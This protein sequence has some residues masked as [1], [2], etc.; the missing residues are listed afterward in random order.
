[1]VA[2]FKHRC[3]EG[4]AKTGPV[5]VLTCSL[6]RAMRAAPCH[7]TV[8][9]ATYVPPLGSHRWVV[10]R[11]QRLL[12]I[13]LVLALP[14]LATAA[15]FTPGNLALYRV[16]TGTGTLV[17][18]GNPVFIDEYSPSGTLV[19]SIALPTTTSASV[20]ACLASGTSTSEGLLSRSS[21]ASALLAT[22]YKRDLGGTG[23][24]SS[25][26]G[27]AV[28]RLVV[29]INGAGAVDTST[30]LA[31]FADGNNPRGATSSDGNALWLA[32]GAGGIRYTTLGA[33]TSTQLSTTVTNLRQPAIFGGNLYVSTGSGSALR[34][35]QVGAGL[36][37]VAGQAITSLPGISPSTGSPYAFVLLDL[38]AG[39]AGMDTLYVADD[40]APALGKFSL[41][42][43]SWV[44]NGSAGVDAD[45]YRGLTAAVNGSAVTLFAT[46][47][48]GSGTT[49]GGELVSLTDLSGYNGA[50]TGTPSLLATATT[51]T[52]FRG[53]ALV[54]TAAQ[55]QPDLTASIAGPA[56][57]V[58]STPYGYTLSLSNIGTAAAGA[59]AASFVLPAGVN[60]DS[61]VANGGCTGSHAAGTVSFSCSGL[62]AGAAASP[63]VSVIPQTAGNVVV[64][65]GSVVADSAGAVTEAN[66]SNNSSTA[67]VTTSVTNG[68]APTIQFDA[69]ATTS[70]LQVPLDGPGAV[71]G[72]IGDST[73]P[74]RTLG[75]AFSLLDA[76][77]AA[78]SLSVSVVSSNLSVV[79]AANL[80]LSGSGAARNLKITPAAVGFSNLTV[81]VSDPQ[82]NTD[83]YVINYAA[84]DGSAAPATTRWHT[85][86]A[87]AST[88]VALDADTM[89]M[90]I[91]EDQ[92]LRLVDRDQS[93]LP[94]AE[95]NVTSL[96]GLTDI[97]G[98]NPREVDIESSVRVGNRIYFM[99]SHSNSAGG[100]LRPNRY[101]LFAVDYTAPASLSYV[102]RYDGLRADLLNWD[103][104]NV[105]GLGANFFGLTASTAAGV[106]P[107]EPNGAGFNIEGLAIAPNGT[108]YLAFRAPI[109]PA[110]ARTRGLIVPVTNLAALVSGNPS[111]GP[112]VFG[113]PIQLDLGGR[114]IRSLDCNASEC[115]IIA[116][117]AASGSFRL[118]T[119]NGDPATQPEERS[120]TLSGLNPEGIVELPATLGASSQIQILSDLGDTVFYGDGVIAKDLPQE[121]WR[122]FRSDLVVLGT[123]PTLSI[124]DV[125]VTEGQSSSILSFTATLSAA[126]SNT[127]VVQFASSDGTATV[128][129]SDYQANAGTLSFPPGVTTRDIAIVVNGDL[130]LET[131]ESMSVTLSAPGGAT[132][133]DGSGQGTITN[134]DSA[135]LA[136]SDASVVEGN[137]AA[138][139]ASFIVT[140]SAAVQGGFTVGVTHANG[141]ASAGSDFTGLA[142]G[143]QLVFVGNAGET[144]ALDAVVLG[145]TV[146]EANET[147]VLTLSTPSNAQVTLADPQATGTI[148]NDDSATISIGNQTAAEGDS[149]TTSFVF[150]VSLNGA[151]QDGF[152]VPYQSADGSAVAPGDYTAATGSLSFTG[153]AGQTRPIAIAVTG[154][155]VA[156][157]TENFFVDLGTPSVAG[158]T[159]STARGTGTI[160]NDDLQADIAVSNSDGRTS[161]LRGETTVYTVTVSNLS[162]VLDVPA[163]QISQT[164]PAALT[165]ISWTCTASGGASCPATGNGAVA[166]TLALPLGSSVSYLVS[167]TV[168]ADASGAT[169]NATVAAQVVSPF[170]DPNA[171]NDSV[172]DSNALLDDL[173]HANGFE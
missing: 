120:A 159:T 33:T 25:T 5:I 170:S 85:G 105:H 11:S 136:I 157:A 119:W 15:A 114:G 51:N 151:V 95:F 104:G 109:V 172:T 12:C 77:T 122:K 65:V 145:D 82:G 102:G 165:N 80:E 160:V 153:S 53:V 66:E 60:F 124:N 24:L 72:V 18:T 21:D 101:R 140:L 42:A 164:L 86:G 123:T 73:D 2:H 49:G 38:D 27:A 19:Q 121:N 52:A 169:I 29:R 39:V 129:D 17:N 35:G 97:S 143:T 142:P 161:L 131:N 50:L 23:S 20:N 79:P 54:P 1:M 171:T 81:S 6:L 117:P 75:L 44:A 98:G 22:C 90:A 167:A 155:T 58:A 115:L 132:I 13:G 7:A 168:A 4:I 103:S 152:S 96:L 31:D 16:G 173:I 40:G 154:D 10:M 128:A 71:S 69:A 110:T 112:A 34:I 26:T 107:E 36:P 144:R 147:F 108:A 134:D 43:G 76:D 91:D 156:E 141:T 84:S 48:G 32:G 8:M 93:G 57:G 135:T 63:V 78:A 14:G 41:V 137:G 113:A 149:G 28:P 87:D 62:A 30:A 100:A 158:V 138:V 116:G 150:T 163:V 125:S 9:D 133:A 56:T 45:D 106:I 46:R 61:V 126:V 59:F 88:A 94:R 166:T 92:R 68:M 146:V 74:A 127:V 3:A 55:S 70:F 118:F 139:N 89:L 130:K 37:V 83:S 162:T 99:G 47:K 67:A 111:A 64:A 148:N